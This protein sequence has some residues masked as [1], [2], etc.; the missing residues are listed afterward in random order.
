MNDTA[1][2]LAFENRA[3]FRVW[4][5]ANHRS[6]DGIWIV[7]QKKN[8]LFTANDALEEAICFGWI[9]GQMK[10]IDETS[11]KKYFSRRVDKANWS[12]KNRGVY[13][14]LEE[15]GL[16]TES[17]KAA[18]QPAE[19]E[20]LAAGKDEIH[21]Q[22]IQRLTEALKNDEEVLKLFEAKPLSRQKQF[23][24]F[25]CEAKTGETRET[26]KAKIID[27]LQS[28]YNGMLY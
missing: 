5:E 1:V 24:G 9:D 10:S 27:A 20:H 16:V 6:S 22:N 19:P 21:A 13:R 3:L 12:E 18:Y 23:A 8:R 11:Y 17:G 14:R 28:N 4:L 26:R 7:L 15:Q 25:Y 2:Q